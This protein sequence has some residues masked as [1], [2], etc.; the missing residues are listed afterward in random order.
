[1]LSYLES[2][3]LLEDYGV[4]LAP[5][6]LVGGADEAVAAAE[7]IG[8]AVALKLISPEHTHKSDMGLVRL[9]LEGAAE[10]RE[11]AL[12]LLAA[13]P[14]SC[15][16]EGLLVQPM[17]TGGC[18]VFLGALVDPQFGP[19]VALGPGGIFVELLGGVDFLRPPFGRGSAAL[20]VERNALRPLLSGVRGRR[21]ADT[22]ALVDALVGL[23]RLILERQNDV[24]SVDVNPFVVSDRGALALD[25]RIEEPRR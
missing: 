22:T 4:P 12:A 23:G 9:G 25:L 14:E 20:F 7:A 1:M 8:G 24:A 5:W 21:P 10:V 2:A 3:S 15:E 17:V 19:L 18:E 13:V 6:K 11:A 16:R